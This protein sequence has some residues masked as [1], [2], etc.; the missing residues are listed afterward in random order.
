ML[1]QRL[2]QALNGMRWNPMSIRTNS[3]KAETG[4]GS[5]LYFMA[6]GLVLGAAIVASASVPHSLVFVPLI[7]AALLAAA[8]D[9]IARKTSGVPFSK[10][11]RGLQIA[12]LVILGLVV[13]GSLLT[14]WVMGQSGEATALSWALAVLVLF[15]VLAGWWIANRHPTRRSPSAS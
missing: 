7:S 15:T 8:I 12:Y 6:N 2:V 4:R 5:L 10:N 13:T 14:V 1:G 3:A 11:F 9:F